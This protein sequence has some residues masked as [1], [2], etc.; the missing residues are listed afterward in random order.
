MALAYRTEYRDMNLD[1]FDFQKGCL[2]GVKFYNCSLC[3]C[4]FNHSDLSYAEFHDCDLYCVEF[5]KAVLYSTK[6]NDCDCTKTS[7]DG[8]YLNGLKTNNIFVV[9]TEFGY[10]F[11]TGKERKPIKYDK[12]I[13]QDFYICKLKPLEDNICNIEKKYNGIYCPTTK[14]AIKFIDD[15]L[16]ERRVWARKSEIAKL[17]KLTLENNGYDDNCLDYYYYQRCFLRKSYKSRLK[18]FLDL[19]FGAF[20]W[21]L[22]C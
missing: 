15:K 22:W 4:K 9:K 10:S 12:T 21:G 2:I 11:N 8:A 7:F 14:I 20:F 17:I 5:N 6:I 1:N 3:Y 18:R 19:V 16:D 13:V